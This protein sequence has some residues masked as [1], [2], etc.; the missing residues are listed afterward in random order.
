MACE[1]SEEYRARRYCIESMSDCYLKMG[2]FD[3][4]ISYGELV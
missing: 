3:E 4:A 2:R 1:V